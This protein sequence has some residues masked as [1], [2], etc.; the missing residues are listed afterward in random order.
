M[1]PLPDNLYKRCENCGR[2]GFTKHQRSLND[3]API[4]VADTAWRTLIASWHFIW[5]MRPIYLANDNRHCSTD[6]PLQSRDKGETTGAV[7]LALKITVAHTSQAVKDNGAL[8]GILSFP[9]QQT[10][11]RVRLDD[12]ILKSVEHGQCFV[13]APHFT[14]GEG[15]L[16]LKNVAREP[17]VCKGRGH[18]TEFDGGADHW[19]H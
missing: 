17:L 14:Q 9:A 8:K 10:G 16:I 13:D 2:T 3:V 6:A 19:T 1:S 18:N 7:A 5:Q 15:Q 12:G 11:L 4:Y